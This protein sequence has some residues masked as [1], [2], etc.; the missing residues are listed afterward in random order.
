MKIF[1][2]LSLSVC[3]AT[4][5]L[6]C[7]DET[8]VNASISPNKQTLVFAQKGGEEEL[9]VES[10]VDW[11][12]NTPADA[13]SWCQATRL[14]EL[15]RVAVGE[16][17]DSDERSVTL[18]LYCEGVKVPVVVEQLGTDPAI[19]VDRKTLTVA[20]TAS[21]A[22][23]NV[24]SNIEYDV[25]PNDSWITVKPADE[26]RAMQSNDVVL[27]FGR[28]D[29]GKKRT[30]SITI[31]PKAEEQKNLAIVVEVVQ[32]YSS[33]SA[34][35]IKD[36][37]V[38]IER[39]EA[40]QQEKNQIWGKQDIMASCDGDVSTFYHSPWNSGK[41]TLPV[42]L[43]YY[44]KEE[45]EID[46]LI[47]T[48]R[49]DSNNG[50]W[51]RVEI[52]FAYNNSPDFKDGI[53]HDFG[54]Q[55]KTAQKFEFGNTMAGVTAVQIQIT[56]SN[57]NLVTCAELGFYR[58]SVGLDEELERIFAD[59]LCIEL[60]PGIG[61]TEISGIQSPFLKELAMKLYKGGYDDYDRQFRVQEYLP[62]RTVSDLQDELKT[63]FGYNQF[64]NPT[65]IFFKPDEDVVV[66][67]DDTKGEVVS[68]KVYDFYNK[69]LGQE[70]NTEVFPLSEGINVYKTTN[71]GLAYV[72]Y[73]TDNYKAALPLKVHVAS[74]QVNG[75][76]EKGKSDAA[77]WQ[78]IINKAEYGHFDLKGDYVNLCFPV[79]ENGGL[80]LYCTDPD[81]LIGI[82][83]KYIKMEFDMMGIEKYGHTF[84]NH[85]FI[86]TV[87]GSPGA[88]AYCDGWGV[89]VYNYD[90]DS[91]NDETCA[92]NKLWMITHEFGHANQINPYLH[93][94]GLGEVTNNCYAVCIRH[95]TIPWFE[96][97][98]D[99]TYN[100]GRGKSVAGGLIN[101]FINQ[102]VLDKNASWIITNTD[103]FIK[104]CPLWQLLCYY[105][106]VE[107][108]HKDWYGDLIEKYR[109]GSGVIGSDNG[110]H[111]IAFMKNTCDVLQADLTDFFENAGMLRPC[112][113]Q[114]GDYNSGRLKITEAQCEDVR[115]YAKRYPKP[116]A[117][118][119]YVSANA[120]RIFKE[121]SSVSG[122]F[123]SGVSLS[124]TTLTV[125]HSVWKNAVAFE[126]YEGNLLSYVSVMG[127]G[128]Q[129]GTS[130]QDV[131]DLPLPEKAATEVYYPASSTAVYAVSWN[132]K[133][134]LVY[135]VSNGIENE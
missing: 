66:F 114:V 47:Y 27:Q 32:N 36:F 12:V 130:L 123:G 9:T 60:N 110:S 30:G 131:K 75:Y 94:V 78:K 16:N 5:L 95:E 125:D 108:E 11:R 67:V 82:Y 79:E 116:E 52:S 73:Y 38:E 74:G 3:L 76:F 7:K 93:W 25:I 4:A 129:N 117:M 132:G 23:F 103:P 134:T 84:S 10:T 61:E 51:G 81:K 99:E 126:V 63:Q 21:E 69:S 88:A 68:L 104:L 100:D 92:I 86:R 121:R 128:R 120:I 102:H 91:F 113:A 133:R 127:T 43:T 6:A 19:K 62:Y 71:G 18:E 35:D 28:N 20:G 112:D 46:Y 39:A 33:Q 14:A 85:M 101:K 42:T 37:Q 64:E 115:N 58:K 34:E 53:E 22:S 124:G 8:V 41:T 72:E 122:R 55:P 83:D 29:T 24:V 90:T 89:G 70:R 40:D 57:D 54:A 17:T 15:L 118:L 98:E 105:R 44:L 45:S 111:Q 1:R 87:P 80:R 77:H 135:G 106:Y 26:S 109:N 49:Q 97:F 31:D 96:K 13:A 59:K 107:T 56:S 119:N 50:A 2:L 65:G 48:P